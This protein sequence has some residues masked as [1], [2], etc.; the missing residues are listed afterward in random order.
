V[1]KKSGGL[2][3]AGESFERH[4][5]QGL[6]NVVSGDYKF[7]SLDK[8]MKNLFKCGRNKQYGEKE[9]RKPRVKSFVSSCAVASIKASV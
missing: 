8:R 2:L 9:C 6:L 1:L 4:L 5:Y 3:I 7:G